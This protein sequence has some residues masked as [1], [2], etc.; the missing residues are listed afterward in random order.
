MTEQVNPEQTHS[1]TLTMDFQTCGNIAA[2]SLMLFSHSIKLR[3]F[4]LSTVTV[5][6]HYLPR[7]RVQ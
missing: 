4:P 7:C 3:A 6:L 1:L 5:S 2:D